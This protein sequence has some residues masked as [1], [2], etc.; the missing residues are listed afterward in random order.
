[1]TKNFLEKLEIKKEKIKEKNNPNSNKIF[2][3]KKFLK[4]E[5]KLKENLKNFKTYLPPCINNKQG[6]GQNNIENLINK[7]E[8]EIKAIDNQ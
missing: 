3:I 2:K 1:M 4:V 6:S 5:S 7:V 8:E